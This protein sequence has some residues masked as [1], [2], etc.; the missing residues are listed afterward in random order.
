M[1]LDDVRV[2]DTCEGGHSTSPH[3]ICASRMYCGA[4]RG[5]IRHNEWSRTR[6]R[7]VQITYQHLRC[8][9]LRKSVVLRS[10]LFSLRL[11]QIMCGHAI[12][13]TQMV[14]AIAT[15]RTLWHEPN[16]AR[17]SSRR[18]RGSCARCEARVMQRV[19]QRDARHTS[20]ARR[21][22]PADTSRSARSRRRTLLSYFEVT[23]LRVRCD[24]FCFN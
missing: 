24:P 6:A 22:A 7:D 17:A 4:V 13:A 11:T 3:N 18:K 12:G 16:V 20:G 15:G 9:H 10:V 14:H 21:H 1:V 5:Q 2:G 23:A 8:P 19:R